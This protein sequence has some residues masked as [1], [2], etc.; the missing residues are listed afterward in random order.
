MIRVRQMGALTVVVHPEHAAPRHAVV[1]R[2]LWLPCLRG[3]TFLRLPHVA[4]APGL[5]GR[6]FLNLRNM[7]TPQHMQMLHRIAFRGAACRHCRCAGLTWHFLQYLGRP[8][9]A[10]PLPCSGLLTSALSDSS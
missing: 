8:L 6:D 9:P 2:P 3:H 4:P 10:T 7:L 5:S 1:V